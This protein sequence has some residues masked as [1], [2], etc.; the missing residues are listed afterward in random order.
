M[1]TPSCRPSAPALRLQRLL[2]ALALAAAALPANVLA[3]SVQFAGQLGNSKA[4]L[5]IDGVPRTLAVGERFAGVRLVS[6]ADGV[7]QVDRDGVASSLRLGGAPV[8]L[9]GGPAR[10]GGREIVMTAGPGGHFRAQH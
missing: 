1:S 8:S 4:L 2:G 6:L 9:A 5:V 7:A 3:Q 10:S